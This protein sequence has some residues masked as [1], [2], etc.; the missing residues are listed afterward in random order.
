M[1]TNNIND[2]KDQMALY[3][4]RIKTFSTNYNNM[5]SEMKT[6]DDNN[7]QMKQ[8]MREQSLIIDEIQ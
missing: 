8:E 3:A 5:K 1:I 2:I 4:A 6:L 7:K